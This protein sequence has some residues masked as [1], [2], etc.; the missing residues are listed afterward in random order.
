MSYNACLM[1]HPDTELRLVNPHIGYGVFATKLIPRGTITWVRDDLDQLFSLDAAER[2]S[3]AI[4][5]FL[6]KYSY[7]NGAGQLVLCWDQARFVNHS[8]E[9]TCL[10]PGLDFEI[11]VRDIRPGEELTDDYGALNLSEPIECACGS[12]RCR[13]IV[14]GDD[15][16]K[17]AAEWDAMV[18]AAFVLIPSVDQPLWPLVDQK[19]DVEHILA[20]R[21]PIPSCL[22]HYWLPQTAERDRHRLVEG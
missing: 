11:A 17:Y 3:P 2:V 5:P 7:M 21:Q 6:D 1:I 8:C 20:G 12:P 9:P 19:A 4:R 16:P 10:S 14:E 18:A 22:Q 15:L 13:R